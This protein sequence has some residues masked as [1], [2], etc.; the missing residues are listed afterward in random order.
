M[1]AGIAEYVEQDFLVLDENGK[2]GRDSFAGWSR[3]GTPYLGLRFG[4]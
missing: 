3:S 4:G 2:H 1:Y